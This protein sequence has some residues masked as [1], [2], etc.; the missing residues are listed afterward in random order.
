MNGHIT[1]VSCGLG[2]DYLTAEHYATVKQADILVGGKRLL[3]WFPDFN[4]EKVPI[5]SHVTETIDKIIIASQSR[6]IAV[7][8]SGDSLFFGIANLFINKV[9]KEK[10]T[11]LPNITAAQAAFS[12]LNIPWSSAEFFTVHGRENILPA[13]NILRADT[14][15]IYCDNTRTPKIIANELIKKYP[16]AANRNAAIAAQLGTDNEII[17]CG[18]LKELTES[19][20]PGMSMLIL[21]PSQSDMPNNVMPR[22]ALGL[23]DNCY[24][25]ENNL[26][27]H[28]EVRAVV[29]SKLQLRSGIMWDLGAGSGSVSIE[30]ACLCKNI[31][32]YAVEKKAHRCEHIKQNAA[33]AGCAQYKIINADILE[34]IQDLPEPDIVF[35][36][37]GGAQIKNILATAYNALRK[38]GTMV[39]TA[40]LEETK[41]AVSTTL[42]DIK[43]EFI[44][45]AIRRSTSLG[46]NKIM[47]PDNPISIFTFKKD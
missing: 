28:P 1:I 17:K 39:V 3:N 10:L 11:I 34:S 40:I 26:I 22:L 8:A 32:V 33:N 37:G 36:G 19:D 16:V 35:I 46:N 13:Y 38:G 29:L 15:V 44:E 41:T 4:G 18:T 25:H 21:L 45:V 23:N 6:K 24:E 27:T 12:L 2:P 20:C 9:P 31:K 5:A 30:A 43:Y 47:K 42:P 7:L 14:A